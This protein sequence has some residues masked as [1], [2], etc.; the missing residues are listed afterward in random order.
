MVNLFYRKSINNQTADIVIDCS[1]EW[2]RENGT[3]TKLLCGYDSEGD[4]GSGDEGEGTVG[5]V[6]DG[7]GKTKSLV[8]LLQKYMKDGKI[9]E[10]RKKVIDSDIAG[11]YNFAY[12]NQ[13]DGLSEL[14]NNARELVIDKFMN[15]LF[16]KTMENRGEEL[17]QNLEEFITN[18]NDLVIGNEIIN[19]ILKQAYDNNQVHIVRIIL[20]PRKHL[21]RAMENNSIDPT[22]HSKHLV[23]AA[24]GGQIE[25]V[26]MSLAWKGEDGRR[27]D[28]TSE[29]NKAISATSTVGHTEIVRMLLAWEGPGGRRVDP[30]S[31]GNMTIDCLG[32]ASMYGHIEIVRVFLAWKGQDGR[33]LNFDKA[34]KSASRLGHTE[35]V[36]L[37]LAREGP[38]GHRVDPTSD[39]NHTVQYKR[40]DT[41]FQ[42]GPYN[43]ALQTAS[44]LGHTEIVRLLLAW[45][46][47]GGLRVDPTVDVNYAIRM[48]TLPGHTETVR[49][50][51]AW[52]GP[53]GRRVDPTSEGNQ[54]FRDATQNGHSEIVSMLLAWEGEHGLTVSNSL[55]S[56]PVLEL[57]DYKSI[58]AHYYGSYL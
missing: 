29:D 57:N 12:F 20:Y 35:I 56:S 6:L 8:A 1:K 13:M 33:Q 46:G 42:H 25:I 31:D 43:D 17:H 50:L 52:E 10:L 26:R 24:M 41:P 4:P 38:G 2:V 45:E 54:A 40:K 49:L 53:R 30:T 9:E 34:M 18:L 27:L 16:D 32:W 3:H 15:M 19:T 21:S 39:G 5:L 7:I 58:M 48:A 22:V 11:L 23:E 36:R 55:H 14:F 47:P 37:F 44:E 28:P 51:L